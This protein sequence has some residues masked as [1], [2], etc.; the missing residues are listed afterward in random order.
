MTDVG[1]LLPTRES[2]MGG[3]PDPGPLLGLAERAEAL[4]YRSVWV[5]DSIV[6]K[7]RHEPLTMLAAV[8]ARTSRVHLGTAVLLPALRDP[9][10]LAHLVAT[11][12]LLS[13]GRLILGIGMAADTPP[14][15]AEFAAV[16]VPY[17]R[18]GQRMVENIDVC[19]SLWTTEPVHRTGDLY[20]L[21]NVQ[22]LPAPRT[23]GGPPIWAAGGGPISIRRAAEHYDGW[24]PIGAN[25]ERFIAGVAEVTELA[26]A[27]GRPRPT[28]AMYLTV[29]VD[30]D[31]ARAE[32][33]L[34]DFL[35]DYYSAPGP[36]VR[37]MQATVAGPLDAV[38]EG[39]ASWATAGADHLVLRF[40]GDHDR[41]LAQLAD[42][43]ADLQQP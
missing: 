8:A 14:N 42:V 4:G 37:K 29:S 23:A 11:V 36:A 6:A 15:R 3:A 12:D 24:F 30:D 7:P 22:M 10:V 35:G 33:T 19:R 5:G 27:A 18:R 43:V 34:E 31:Q 28:I 13:A 26:E 16:G 2:V 9:V 1:Y 40:V 38:A 25:Q 17:R 32:S 41:H 39:I 21:D 20:P